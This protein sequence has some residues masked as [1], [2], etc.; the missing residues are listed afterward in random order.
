[1]LRS[2]IDG[3][4]KHLEKVEKEREQAKE[5]AAAELQTSMQ[6]PVKP[7]EQQIV[8]FFRSLSN[9]QISRPWSLREITLQ[10]EGKYRDRPHPQQV[11]EILRKL[12]WQ[13]RR[14]YGAEW[15]GKR[16]WFPPA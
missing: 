2:Y 13:R 6:P 9:T 5:S 3:L 8:E 14:L 15:A 16:Y 12:G 10:L 11:G 7:L 1:M 4:Y